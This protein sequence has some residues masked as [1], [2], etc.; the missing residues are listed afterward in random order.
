[1][2]CIKCKHPA[3]KRFGTYGPRK[4]QRFR[5]YSC[6]STFSD[7]KRPISGHYISIEK[8]SQIVS[9]M[10]EG[11][12]IRA[13]SRLTGT[14]KK[15]ILALIL[16]VGKKCR[17]TFDAKVRNI[18][19]NFVELDELWCFIHSREK[20][21]PLNAPK[22]WGDCYTWIGLDSESK[23]IISYLVGK[24]DAASAGRFVW[25][26]R[27]R[28]AGRCQITSDGFRAYVP[29]IER[30][31]GADVDFAQ[32]VKVYGTPD[33]AG[34]EWYGPGK[35]IDAIPTPISGNPDL[36]YVSTSHVERSN[37]TVRMHLRR[38]TRLTNA[39]SKSL[40]H[41]QAAVDIFMAWYNLCRYHQT[42]RCTPAMQAGL[43]DH[44]W[45]VA[46]LL[47]S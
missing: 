23:L 35:V 45:T 38:Y 39:H 42:I 6:K 3:V 7:S 25:D 18:Q 33:S 20:H 34:P 13:I 31:F 32:L 47:Q 46:E 16:T 14:D 9:M 43:T 15:T 29:A 11:M 10:M 27:S 17:A 26:L 41:L 24:R 37:L 5:C 4:I 1:M 19:P 12:S 40:P 30:A 22:E 36:D 28:I 8:A 44:I 21:V 2:T